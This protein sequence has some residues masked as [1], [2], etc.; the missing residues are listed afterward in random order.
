MSAPRSPK[1]KL[2]ANDDS[3]SYVAK[4]VKPEAED[5]GWMRRMVSADASG[6]KGADAAP[7]R[8]PNCRLLSLGPTG[9]VSEGLPS[10][11]ARDTGWRS[12]EEPV[13]SFSKPSGRP[14]PGSRYA[15]VCGRYGEYVCDDG[16]RRVQPRR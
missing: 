12:P 1:I 7:T 15:W 16:R 2:N 5:R 10:L 9:P 13:K 3:G 14:S 11:R 8:G 4:K 6:T